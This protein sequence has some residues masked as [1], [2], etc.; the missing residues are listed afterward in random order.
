M[1]AINCFWII[2]IFVNSHPVIPSLYCIKII[3]Y[4]ISKYKDNCSQHPNF[5]TVPR[6]SPNPTDYPQFLMTWLS[7]SPTYTLLNTPI[8]A[9]I[10][11]G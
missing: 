1:T 11:Q 10:L 3:V 8:Q 5:S 4:H 9:P 2:V 7:T 6:R